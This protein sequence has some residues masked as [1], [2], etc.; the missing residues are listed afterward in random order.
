M[1]VYLSEACF[2]CKLNQLY[3]IKIMYHC[4]NEMAKITINNHLV[5]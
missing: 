4:K 3:V 2:Y 1:I 5:A